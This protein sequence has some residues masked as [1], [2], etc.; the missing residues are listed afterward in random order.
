M[1]YA[2]ETLIVE[3]HR[4]ISINRM[5]EV[6]TA[7]YDEPIS[8]LCKRNEERIAEIDEAVAAIE[9]KIVGV[10]KKDK[11]R[12]VIHRIIETVCYHLDVVEDDIYSRRKTEEVVMTRKYIYWIAT[13]ICGVKNLIVA[14]FFGQDHTTG[15]H[16]VKS[17]RDISDVNEEVRKQMEYF[18]SLNLGD[19]LGDLST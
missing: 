7:L 14:R 10:N 9:R 12:S 5:H 16:A 15:I 4:L 17:L 11:G 1:Q 3:K 6:K 8:N 18:R 2:I 13:E 19:K